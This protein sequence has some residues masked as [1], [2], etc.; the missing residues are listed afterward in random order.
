MAQAILPDLRLVLVAHLTETP[1]GSLDAEH[2]VD[3]LAALTMHCSPREYFGILLGLSSGVLCKHHYLALRRRQALEAGTYL[4]HPQMSPYAAGQGS[5]D[6]YV[7]SDG[8]RL[9]SDY[10]L[11]P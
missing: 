9:N 6:P 4:R 2:H 5:P 3:H 10:H 8:L 11:H 1:G 7:L